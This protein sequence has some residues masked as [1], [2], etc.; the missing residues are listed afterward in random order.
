MNTNTVTTTAILM[1]SVLLSVSTVSG[2]ER[3]EG[4]WPLVTP[5]LGVSDP[6]FQASR[7]YLEDLSGALTTTE[8]LTD[9]QRNA[10][11]MFD[12]NGIFPFLQEGKLQD[13]TYVD[14]CDSLLALGKP[15]FDLPRIKSALVLPR[16]PSGLK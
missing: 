1:T 8:T 13:V 9:Q 4:L 3:S 10:L 16:P 7:Q 6:C 14:L 15:S 2:Q 12:S 5:L 11:Q